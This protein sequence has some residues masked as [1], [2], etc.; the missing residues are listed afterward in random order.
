MGRGQRC[1]WGEFIQFNA[2]ELGEEFSGICRFW[3]SSLISMRRHLVQ[4]A[5]FLKCYPHGDTTGGRIGLHTVFLNKVISY[6]ILYN[7][8]TF[9][10]VCH[11]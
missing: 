7:K 5:L 1:Y 8:S 9:L 11:M 2:C 4:S 6:L 3:A 10:G